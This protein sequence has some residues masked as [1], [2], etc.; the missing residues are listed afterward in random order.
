[1]P[2]VTVRLLGPPRVERDGIAVIFETRKVL[3]LLAYLAVQGKPVPRE[4]LAA[5]LWPD[6]DG[7]H[8]S[9]DLRRALSSLRKALGDEAVAA[10]RRTVSLT[11]VPD[12]FDLAVFRHALVQAAASQGEAQLSSLHEA[13]ELCRDAFMAGFSL[14]DSAEFDDWQARERDQVESELADCLELLI[15]A[16]DARGN[17]IQAIAYARRWLALD[18][19]REDAHRRLMSLYGR[20]GRRDEALRQYREC[21]RILE[22]DLGVPPLAE[23]TALYDAIKENR[24]APVAL[25]AAAA[26]RPLPAAVMPLTGRDHEWAAMAGALETWASHGHWIALEGEPGIGKSRL[27]DDFVVLARERGHAVIQIGCHEGESDLA[28]EPVTQALRATFEDSRLA[29]RLGGLPAHWRIELARLMPELGPGAIAGGAGAQARLF[30]A[31][32]QAW[33]L[34]A[35]GG[36]LVL[37][38][39]DLHWADA[40]SIDLIAY[41]SRRLAG[42]RVML[43]TAWREEAGVDVTRLR[44]A[45]AEALRAGRALHLV[46]GRLTPAQ[47]E[48]LARCASPARAA[49]RLGRRL[50]VESEGVP[51]LVAE[52]LRALADGP[53]APGSAW[54]MPGNV[55]ELLRARVYAL[56]ETSRQVLQAA[57]VLGRS[58]DAALAEQASG[59]SDE[60]AA[61]ALETLIARGMVR[62]TGDESCDFVHE[63]LR[64]LVYEGI[65]LGRRRLLHLRIAQSIARRARGK[66]AGELAGQAARHFQQAGADDDAARCYALAGD[67]ARGAFAN[68]SALAHYTAALELGHPDEAVLREALGDLRALHGEYAL[69]AQTYRAAFGLAS[70]SAARGRIAHKLGNVFYRRGDWDQAE[71]QY[72]AAVALD[73]GLGRAEVLADWSRTCHKRGDDARARSLAAQALSL[74]Q[75]AG[76]PRALAQAHNCAGV[77]ARHAGD[78]SEAR[79][80]FGRSLQLARELG[81]R[82]SEIAAMNNLGLAQR[83]DGDFLAAMALTQEALRLCEDYGDRHGE[84]ALRSNLADLL[85]DAGEIPAAMEQL[86]QSVVILAEIGAD[87]GSLQPEVWKL[88]EW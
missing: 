84:A 65:P 80:Q 33:I 6:H 18:P 53:A 59:R 82:A 37:A 69:A 1:M 83:D 2:S 64:E 8:A 22:A 81:D 56:D 72:E 25:A 86:K 87:T 49:D 54:P 55:R 17:L 16:Q 24:P 38:F 28:H 63:K 58:F 51:L 30:E 19:L 3:A 34:A 46:L 85:R 39:D 20:A 61:A 29:A 48:A 62:G 57:A 78:Y 75:A 88:T 60:E 66:R 11:L 13:A 73:G 5:L 43:I 15:R 47:V 12:Q 40:A 32:R 41:L 31:A 45:L 9:G 14:R 74:A 67:R 35:G 27:M 26:L 44:H 71:A 36:V 52:Y 21:E 79:D 10:D 77:L 68:A 70:A 76:E 4:T 7:A 42:T 23:T 50:F